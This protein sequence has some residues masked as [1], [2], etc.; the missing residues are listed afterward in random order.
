MAKSTH[1][2]V[3]LVA[4]ALLLVCSNAEEQEAHAFQPGSHAGSVSDADM[5]KAIRT[6]LMRSLRSPR[7]HGGRRYEYVKRFPEVN[8][9]GFE[10]DIFDEGFGEFS[11][12]RRR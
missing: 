1:A 12:V 11:P 7:Y 8:A 2:M 4:V 3:M 6:V 9:R 5:M 10:S